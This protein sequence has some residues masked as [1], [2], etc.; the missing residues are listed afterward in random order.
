MRKSNTAH[1]VALLTVVLCLV[2]ASCSQSN[3]VSQETDPMDDLMKGLEFGMS[4]DDMLKVDGTLVDVTVPVPGIDIG[5]TYRSSAQ[6]FGKTGDRTISIIHEKLAAVSFVFETVP[7]ES[8]SLDGEDAVRE[9]CND[10]GSRITAVYGDASDS[11]VS[12][13]LVP[14]QK[15][16]Q[17]DGRFVGVTYVQP[18]PETDAGYTISVQTGSVELSTPA[19]TTNTP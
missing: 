16:W 14:Y 3:A 12:Q 13:P 19:T 18:T 9:W 2:T 11:P 1:F 8:D 6:V 10:L 4:I 5:K 7:S 17:K 15:I